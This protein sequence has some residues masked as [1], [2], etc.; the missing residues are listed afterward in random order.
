V[1]AAT[2]TS[3]ASVAAMPKLW[4]YAQIATVFFVIV[5]MIIAVIRLA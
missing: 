5:G 1:V 3:C 4:I 2:A